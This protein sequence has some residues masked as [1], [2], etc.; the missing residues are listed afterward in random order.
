MRSRWGLVPVI[1]LL[2]LFLS[3]IFWYAPFSQP[4]DGSVHITNDFS[5][6]GKYTIDYVIQ[7]SMPIN[8]TI[9]AIPV[10]SVPA[11][12]PVYVFFDPDYSIAELGSDWTFINRVWEH[13]AIQLDLRNY[14][15]TVELVND[16]ELANIF[17]AKAP[18]VVIVA[19][20]AF[21][22]NV[23]SSTT[24]LVQ[25]WVESG[26]V[27]IWFGWE[28]GYYSVEPSGEL[29]PLGAKGIDCIKMAE[30][31]Q[32]T[33]GGP[34]WISADKSTLL[35]DA[36]DIRYNQV[37]A[38]PLFHEVV[39]ADGWP[40][41]FVGD[42]NASLR[43][44]V[45]AIPMGAGTVITFGFFIGTSDTAGDRNDPTSFYS[46]ARDISQILSSSIL[47]SS[48]LKISHQ[49][50]Q[51]ANGESQQGSLTVSISP[52]TIGV[53]VY[54]YNDVDSTGLLFFKQYVPISRDL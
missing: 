17:L 26:G 21:P 29:D 34:S 38:A 10:S 53:V 4:V 8:A 47:K 30:Y 44:S 52:E 15:S 1:L 19:T 18:A 39:V 22:S 40:L 45:S 49:S 5:T 41:G 24:N 37:R 36:L 23:F 33:S 46:I 11:D 51:L 28:M 7:A 16:Q 54:G 6:D 14:S 43:I 27:M 25:P 20:G 13:L 2:F 50:Y 48:D 42:V 31:V 12:L 35:S 9:V 3:Q 32:I